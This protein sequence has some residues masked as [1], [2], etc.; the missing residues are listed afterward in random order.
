MFVADGLETLSV[1]DVHL[2]NILC[3]EK[4]K[5]DSND[6][7]EHEFVM[8][9]RIGEKVLYPSVNLPQAIASV[10][11]LYFV[12]NL[13]YPPE[14]D[15]LLQFL[16]RYVLNFGKEEGARN[17]RGVIKHP[18]NKFQVSNFPKSLIINQTF[19]NY[20]SVNWAVNHNAR[21]R[22]QIL[23]PKSQFCWI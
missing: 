23:M 18:F 3:V 2:P 15:N 21:F 4:R 9:V 19:N 13:E 1:S 14:A 16:Q 22:H 8:R 20:F 7:Y 6:D 5:L 10:V 11:A 17:R 12:M